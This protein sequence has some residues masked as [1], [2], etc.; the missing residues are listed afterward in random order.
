M[1]KFPSNE[2]TLYIPGPPKP[3][4]HPRSS[5]FSMTT[6]AAATS[7]AENQRIPLVELQ[8]AYQKPQQQQPQSPST[9]TEEWRKLKSSQCNVVF[10]NNGLTRVATTTTTKSFKTIPRLKRSA[11]S[12]AT[13]YPTLLLHGQQHQNN[14]KKTPLYKNDD[15]K[16]NSPNQEPRFA[17]SSSGNHKLE[18]NST[19]MNH[20]KFVN[21]NNT[22]QVLPKSILFKKT[23]IM[24]MYK[25]FYM[26][27]SKT[28]GFF[29]ARNC[30][31]EAGNDDELVVDRF[32]AGRKIKICGGSDDEIKEQLQPT[33]LMDRDVAIKVFKLESSELKQ[34]NNYSF[35]TEH[36]KCA[37]DDLRTELL[38][39]DRGVSSNKWSSSRLV[40]SCTYD[41]LSDSLMII[42]HELRIVN[43]QLILTQ[44]T[45]F[46]DILASRQTLSLPSKSSNSSGIW[47]LNSSTD[48]QISFSSIF[49]VKY[50]KSPSF[51]MDGIWMKIG[52]NE[53]TIPNCCLRH[54][55]RNGLI[56]KSPHFFRENLKVICISKEYDDDKENSNNI[57][58]VVFYECKFQFGDSILDVSL[59]STTISMKKIESSS[60]L[61]GT[62][63]LAWLLNLVQINTIVDTSFVNAMNKPIEERSGGLDMPRSTTTTK[64]MSRSQN[65][66]QTKKSDTKVSA[67]L[68]QKQQSAPT[69]KVITPE[70][71]QQMIFVHQ[72]KCLDF[73]QKQTEI[74][75]AQIFGALLSSNDVAAAQIGTSMAH[76]YNQSS[77]SIMATASNTRIFTHHQQSVGMDP[78]YGEDDDD[79]FDYNVSMNKKTMR[80]DLGNNQTFIK[81]E[82]TI[83]G[84]N[85]NNLHN[86]NN[87]NHYYYR[88]KHENNHI[89]PEI[90]NEIT[91]QQ[92][93]FRTFDELMVTNNNNENI[94]NGPS[95]YH[96]V[97]SKMALAASRHDQISNNTY[98]RDDRNSQNFKELIGK[99]VN[100]P[101][102]S[103]ILKDSSS[104]FN[105]N[106]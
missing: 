56:E 54:I 25:N 83:I 86:Y 28:S 52:T 58:T 45:G 1:S 75:Q 18:W 11:G 21:L 82:T 12:T 9:I 94:D 24:A 27:S 17:S 53:S 100:D 10:G 31:D 39:D 76:H 63:P 93:R 44:V 101:E 74:L 22:G 42:Y 89:D 96:D 3:R 104:N 34:N 32:D 92:Q 43:V 77:S 80:C 41:T 14:I 19:P 64:T 4:P 70:T 81:T 95:P 62:P 105:N 37:L 66:D 36:F 40:A 26:Q 48:D 91:S 55:L 79:F 59:G 60:S 67:S 88:E 102:Q 90:Y 5:A 33:I 97:E 13:Y 46:D 61:S 103:F 78:D 29:I 2:I 15:I 71:I 7:V 69:L 68:F 6:P 85:N 65:S 72:Q 16:T 49:S 98:R 50:L 87:N 57:N 47:W 20:P 38:L 99:F 51:I 35:Q 30:S 8:P 84:R 73:L 106:K 23:A